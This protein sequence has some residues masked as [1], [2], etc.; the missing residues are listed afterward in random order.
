M[1]T[2]HR[3]VQTLDEFGVLVFWKCLGE[4]IRDNFFCRLELERDHCTCIPFTQKV[5][6]G[7]DVLGARVIHE[8]LGQSDATLIVLENRRRYLAT[9]VQ[10]FEQNSK[11]NCFLRRAVQTHVLCFGT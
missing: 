4:S 3:H 5:K 7:V 11:S 10:V 8:I 2:L 1:C 9:V 6:P